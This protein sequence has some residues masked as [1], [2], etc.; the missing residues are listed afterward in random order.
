MEAIRTPTKRNQNSVYNMICNTQSL[1]PSETEW[2][3]QRQDLAAVG[4]G[5]E[6][7]WFNGFLEDL[8]NKI[9]ARLLL[10][11]SAMAIIKDCTSMLPF[12]L[13]G[14][15]I[16]LTCAICSHSSPQELAPILRI[17][18]LSASPLKELSVPI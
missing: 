13:Q 3:R 4:H 10:V 7:G 12:Q 2:I 16:G 6:Y 18:V 14:R 15:S 9:S 8:L 11:S 1:V 17:S 5:A